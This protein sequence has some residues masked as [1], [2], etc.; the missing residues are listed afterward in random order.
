VRILGIRLGRRASIAGGVGAETA[1]V[2]VRH[3]ETGPAIDDALLD[4]HERLGQLADFRDR[5][6]EQK[7]R[8]PLGRLGPIPG[9]R[10]KASIRRATGSG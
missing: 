7:E 5:T 3:V 8:E 1:R 2:L 9:S 10:W 6:L 4:G